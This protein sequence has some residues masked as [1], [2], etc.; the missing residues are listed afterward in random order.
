MARLIK[1]TNYVK[2]DHWMADN[3]RS[4]RGILRLPVYRPIRSHPLSRLWLL[5]GETEGTGGT[6]G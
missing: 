2:E 3:P 4:E 5:T 6:E 1:E